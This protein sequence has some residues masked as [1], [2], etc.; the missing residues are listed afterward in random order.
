MGKPL[1]FRIGEKVEHGSVINVT[2]NENYEL[3]SGQPIECYNG[4]WTERTTCEPARCK[5][6][7]NPPFNGMVVVSTV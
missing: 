3:R 1:N 2:C 5:T 6:L 7:P 4:T